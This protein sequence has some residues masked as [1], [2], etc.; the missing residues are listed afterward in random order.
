MLALITTSVYAYRM[1]KPRRITDFDERN[2]VILNDTLEELWNITNGRMTEIDDD[3]SVS[4]RVT[5]ENIWHAYGGFQ[6]ANATITIGTKE[7]WYH[8]T[9]GSNDLWTGLEGD[10]LTLSGDK[11]TFTNGGDYVGHVAIDISALTGKDYHIRL[12]NNTQTKVMGYHIGISTTGAGN[13]VL[14]SMPLYLEI[15]AGDELQ[16]EIECIT[17]ATDVVLDNAIFFLTYLHD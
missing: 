12:Y 1:P 6:D 4:G 7:V 16:M 14:L 5:V 13:N 8:I 15:T 9:N 10:G 2:L 17:S 3:L 11:M